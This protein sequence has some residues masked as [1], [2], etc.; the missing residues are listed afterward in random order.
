MTK[1]QRA[2]FCPRCHTSNVAPV[3]LCS[4][5]GFN[6]RRAAAIKAAVAIIGLLGSLGTLLIFLWLIQHA[7]G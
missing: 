2:V 1:K 6:I 4:S 3:T 5:C 7:Q